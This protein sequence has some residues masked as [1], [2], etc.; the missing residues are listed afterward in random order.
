LGHCSSRSRRLRKGWQFIGVGIH[1]FG[2]ARGT[3]EGG[4]FVGKLYITVEGYNPPVQYQTS[5]L[6]VMYVMQTLA[7]LAKS[8]DGKVEVL[9]TFVC[10]GG[11]KSNLGRAYEGYVASRFRFMFNSLF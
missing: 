3:E 9:V 1:E 6:F 11:I 7:S 2:W 8:L 10:P 4:E 5:K